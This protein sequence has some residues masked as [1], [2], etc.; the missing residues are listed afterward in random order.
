M[1][2]WL[3]QIANASDFEMFLD[4]LKSRIPQIR[5]SSPRQPQKISIISDSV[6]LGYF[7]GLGG[8]GSAELAVAPAQTR[9]DSLAGRGVV[10]GAVQVKFPSMEASFER[11]INHD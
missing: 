3:P 6:A 9:L 8:I 4:V 5:K 10:W 1:P 11:P 2:L 7:V